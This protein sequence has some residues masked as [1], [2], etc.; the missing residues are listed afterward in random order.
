MKKYSTLCLALILGAC[1]F[2]QSASAHVVVY[3]REAV[4]GSYEKFTVRVPSEKEVPTVKVEVRIPDEV[5]ISRFEPKPGWSYELVMDS[6]DK[7]TT[8]IWNAEGDGLSATEFGEF[9][10]QGKINND[11]EALV[12]KAYQ[13]YADGTVAEW[14]GGAGSD[15]PAST[16]N[17]VA[18]PSNQT[19]DSN[20]SLPLILSIAAQVVALLALALSVR[21]RR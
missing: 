1:L 6:S 18:A 14:I 17:I 9:N 10:M 3:P 5:N 4:Q 2:A 8:V 15:H 19:A 13:T 20:S 11:A 7:I 21:K 12:W 16:T